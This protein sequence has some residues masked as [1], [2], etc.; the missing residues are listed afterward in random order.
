MRKAL[1]DYNE[2]GGRY[3]EAFQLL[4]EPAVGNHMA[5]VIQLEG[6]LSLVL[7]KLAVALPASS[8]FR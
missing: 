2:K 7:G 6:M 1:L 5:R 8:G 4:R 3:L